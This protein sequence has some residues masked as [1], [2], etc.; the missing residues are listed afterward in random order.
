[1]VE[2][3][4]QEFDRL[5]YALKDK[6]QNCRSSKSIQAEVDQFL[7]TMHSCGDPVGSVASAERIKQHKCPPRQ[8][9]PPI[10]L[11][12]VSE[13]GVE[14]VREPIGKDRVVVVVGLNGISCDRR[15]CYAGFREVISNK[16]L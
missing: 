15:R 8:L 1:M 3:L 9:H 13:D 5:L 7:I 12:K 10:F 16:S 6:L 11:R 14:I 2:E 4:V